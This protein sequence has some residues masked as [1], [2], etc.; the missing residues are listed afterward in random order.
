[1]LHFGIRYSIFDILAARKVTFSTKI[2]S[3][4]KTQPQIF[5]PNLFHFLR[6]YIHFTLLPIRENTIIGEGFSLGNPDRFRIL[7]NPAEGGREA[8]ASGAA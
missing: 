7:E 4:S 8:I 1:L 2:Y 5:F 6:N 3:L